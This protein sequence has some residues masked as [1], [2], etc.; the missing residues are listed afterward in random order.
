MDL[1]RQTE[2]AAQA[3][4]YLAGLTHEDAATRIA[5]LKRLATRAKAA[6]AD[7]QADTDRRVAEIS[8][9]N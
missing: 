7:I 8:E 5:A 2:M 9:G 4:D 6:A 3:I 1:K